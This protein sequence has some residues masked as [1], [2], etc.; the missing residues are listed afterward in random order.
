MHHAKDW[1]SAVSER[2]RYFRTHIR[3]RFNPPRFL[4]PERGF[5]LR[6]RDGSHLTDVDAAI[7]DRQ[8]G[9]LALVQLKWPDI[10]GLSPKERE[11]RRRN[12]LNANEW[13]ERVH[14][15]IN[16]R[17]A[18]EVGKAL[19]NGL[20][21]SAGSPLLVVM[22]R[23]NAR[24]ALN[25]GLDDRAAWVSWP[26]VVRLRSEERNLT[27]PLKTLAARFRAGGALE[28][29]GPIPDVVY[30]LHGLDVRLSAA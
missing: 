26:E 13:V 19:G 8:T 1:D 23:Y 22:P 15:W 11:S 18:A 12:L 5:M 10:F 14:S 29:P 21:A 25:T 3:N 17:S 2:E 28:S 24:F 20:D 6:R 30:N 9:T 16:G 4:V 7:L 27:D